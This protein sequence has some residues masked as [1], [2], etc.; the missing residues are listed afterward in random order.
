MYRFVG[1]IAGVL[2][3][4]ACG[5]RDGGGATS[6]TTAMATTTAVAAYELSQ[7][8][9]QQVGVRTGIPGDATYSAQLRNTASRGVTFVVTVD[10]VRAGDKARVASQSQTVEALSPGQFAAVSIPAR[11]VND[12]RFSAT[13]SVLSCEVRGVTTR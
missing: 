4:A 5:A 1:L 2:F 7:E 13:G 3:V 10:F 11:W 12:G 9:C 6:V 8:Q